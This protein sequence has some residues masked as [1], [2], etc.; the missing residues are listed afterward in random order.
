MTQR[1]TSE[2]LARQWRLA[3]SLG[4]SPFG[5]TVRQ[6]TE[7]LR[8]S[9]STLYRDLL[10]LRATGVTIESA[11]VSGRVHLRLS[12]APRHAVVPSPLQL[13]ALK[14]ARRSLE[15]LEGTSG[16]QEL[17][18]LLARW[19]APTLRPVRT[20]RPQSRLPSPAVHWVEAALTRGNNIVLT[21]RS[22]EGWSVIRCNVTPLAWVQHGGRLCLL[23]VNVDDST[24]CYYQAARIV[25][26]EC[27]EEHRF[28]ELTN[29]CSLP[30]AQSGNEIEVEV[31]LA[32]R[33]AGLAL[34]HPLGDGQT[35]E[36]DTDNTLIVRATAGS[37]DDARRWVL[38]WGADAEALSPDVLRSSLAEE[39]HRMDTLYWRRPFRL[40]SA[41]KPADEP[42]LMTGLPGS[43]A[44]R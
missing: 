22:D 40:A 24:T 17:D 39:A 8:V 4:A 14:L 9:R 3:A 44:V 5:C 27:D 41:S 7:R 1:R 42:L 34:R 20:Q 30:P 31:R 23:A 32:A 11:T 37:L 16:V 26:V 43:A 13:A 15:F 12:D 19:S 29:S 35:I 33:V 38:S 10:H 6:L 36:P 2:T 28:A 18:A 21:V 25:H